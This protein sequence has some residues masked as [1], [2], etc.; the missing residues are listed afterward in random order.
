M[1]ED[2]K[3]IPNFK[4]HK[5]QMKMPFVIYADFESLVIP[6][7]GRERGPEEKQK[8][9]TERTHWHLACGYSYIVVRRDGKVTGWRVYRGKNAVERFF[10]DIVQE[11]VKIR[12]SLSVA[13]PFQMKPENWWRFKTA[14]NCHICN[15][16][17]IKEEFLHSLPVW[18]VEEE[19][20]KLC[21]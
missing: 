14:K 16:S 5:K 8:S 2:G 20:E 4:N 19:D 1:P 17:L 3:N 18:N 11:E 9:Y 13:V 7:K 6:I 15:K 10:E 12:E 21:Y